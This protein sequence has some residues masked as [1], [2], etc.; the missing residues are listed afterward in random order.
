MEKTQFIW[1]DTAQQLAK[2]NLQTINLANVIIQVSDKVTCLGIVIF[3]DNVK[4][5]TGSR[6]YT[7][8]DNCVR[9]PL[10]TLQK[11]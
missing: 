1:P 3:A 7:N 6:F 11:L 2:V 10:L 5:Q 8:W 9:R 4:K